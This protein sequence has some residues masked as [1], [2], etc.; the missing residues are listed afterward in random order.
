LAC[1]WHLAYISYYLQFQHFEQV[2]DFYS[3][4]NVSQIVNLNAINRNI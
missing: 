2:A 1:S 4:D 3:A